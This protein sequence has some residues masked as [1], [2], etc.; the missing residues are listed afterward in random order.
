MTYSPD[1]YFVKPSEKDLP[2]PPHANICVKTHSADEKA[3]EVIK[4]NPMPSIEMIMGWA[5]RL[6]F[7]LN[8]VV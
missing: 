7:S 5:Y 1:L 8:R 2:G 6:R 3:W 4:A